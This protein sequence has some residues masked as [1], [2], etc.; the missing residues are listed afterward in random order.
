MKYNI[1]VTA[2]TG[3]EEFF[4]VNLMAVEQR[5]A[6]LA[7][8]VFLEP[9]TGAT[10]NSSGPR[11]T[12]GVVIAPTVVATILLLVVLLILVGSITYKLRSKRYYI[13]VSVTIAEVECL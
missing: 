6:D 13:R 11:T 9:V 10:V 4:G 3:T 8:R 1:S 2:S 5:V 7:R 12:P